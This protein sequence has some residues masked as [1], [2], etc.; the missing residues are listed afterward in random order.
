MT[1][2][3]KG[4]RVKM[5]PDSVFYSQALNHKGE[6]ED[7]T[8]LKIGTSPNFKYIVKWDHIDSSNNYRELDLILTSTLHQDIEELWKKLN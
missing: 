3:K 7:G 8:V 1:T 4:D 5:N 2:F 6:P